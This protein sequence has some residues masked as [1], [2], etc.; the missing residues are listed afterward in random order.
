LRFGDYFGKRLQEIQGCFFHS[1]RTTVVEL[2]ENPLRPLEIIRV[3]R[4]E[5]AR[6]VVAEAEAFDLA[7]ER[8]DVFLGRLARMLAGL[9]GVLLGGQAERVPAHRMQHVEALR[10]FVAR[11]NVRGGVAFGMPDVQARA[12]RIRKHV[13]DVKFR[14]QLCGGHFCRKDHGVCKR[15]VPAI[16]SPGLNARKACC[17]SQIFCHLGSIK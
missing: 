11:Q 7:L 16:S 6:P 17:S 15:M 14:R 5:F 12:A 8:G 9:D 2:Q 1:D 10:A 3:G 13:E 4:G